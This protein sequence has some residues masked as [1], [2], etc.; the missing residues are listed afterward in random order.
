M[1]VVVKKAVICELVI[2]CLAAYHSYARIQWDAE[3]FMPLS[4]VKRGMKGKGYTVF[5]GTTVE[6]FEY[7][8]YP[9]WHV[10]WGEGL[11]DN[12]KNT[13]VA[14]G[15]SGSPMYINGRLIG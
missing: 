15:M 6:E 2:F 13:G 3:T 4:E 11:S 7:N 10:V 8:L 14:M 1:S 5:S 12:F 9:G